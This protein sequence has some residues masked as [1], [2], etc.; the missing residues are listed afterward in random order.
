MFS[1]MYWYNRTDRGQP[2]AHM[3]SGFKIADVTRTDMRGIGRWVVP[4]FLLG[5]L[6]ALLAGL[7]WAYRLGEDQWIEGGWRETFSV[8]AVS[9]ANE[10]INSAKGPQWKEIAFI[11]LGG[12]TTLALAKL[13]YTFI[14]FPFHPIGFALAMCY[15]MEYNWPAYM[16]IWVLKGLVLRYGGRTLYFRLAPFFLGLVLGGLVIPVLWGFVAWLFEWYK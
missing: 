13:S 2:M 14:G 5:S 8:V 10:W 4:A 3:L 16:G 15:T 7:H 6:V 9:R 11:S 1:L 12:A